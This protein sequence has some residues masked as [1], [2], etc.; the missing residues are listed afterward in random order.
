M[1]LEDQ[2]EVHRERQ[3]SVKQFADEFAC[4][5]LSNEQARDTVEKGSPSFA[6]VAI[7]MMH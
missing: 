7:A 3:E 2:Q 6:S 4:N 5:T 1:H